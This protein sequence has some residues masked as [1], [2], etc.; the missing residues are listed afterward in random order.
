MAFYHFSLHPFPIGTLLIGMKAMHK[1]QQRMGQQRVDEDFESIRKIQFPAAPSLFTSLWVT[2][3]FDPSIPRKAFEENPA[4]SLGYFYQVE[5]QGE[6]YEVEPHWEVLACRAVTQS[7]LKGMQLQNYID[8]M[9][10]KFWT[11]S[12]VSATVKDFLCPQ[13]ALITAFIRE[14]KVTEVPGGQLDVAL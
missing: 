13:G 12:L 14:V 6:F 1:K 7:G 4:A 9:A 5:P 11:P 10:V 3:V 2:N 8:E